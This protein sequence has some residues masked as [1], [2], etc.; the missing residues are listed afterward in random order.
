MPKVKGKPK[1][2]EKGKPSG[3]KRG[4]FVEGCDGAI[5][6]NGLPR[7]AKAAKFTASADDNY[8][9]NINTLV[10]AEKPPPEHDILLLILGLGPRLRGYDEPHYALPIEH[11]DIKIMAQ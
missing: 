11:E 8:C 7:P 6:D 9:T 10:G 5:L 1:S 4:T 2:K 3:K